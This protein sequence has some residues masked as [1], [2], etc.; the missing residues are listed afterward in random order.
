MWGGSTAL[1]LTLFNWYTTHRIETLY[2]IV[3]RFV[4]SMAVG[5]LMGL[6]MWNTLRR[7]ALGHKK[8]TRTGNIL[9]GVL[10]V[11]LML[12]LSYALWTMSR[13]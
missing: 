4:I 9:R 12:G 6:S 10:F 13:H 11:T 7:E 8:L 5:V 3:A 1:A 2:Q